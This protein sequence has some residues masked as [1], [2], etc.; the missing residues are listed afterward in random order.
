MIEFTVATAFLSGGKV[1]AAAANAANAAEA[2]AAA[3][4]KLFLVLFVTVDCPRVPCH[5]GPG[6][7]RKAKHNNEQSDN[8]HKK[9]KQKWT[10]KK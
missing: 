5:F 10:A 3:V 1:V 9:E 7:K 4:V 8:V 6:Q 2:A